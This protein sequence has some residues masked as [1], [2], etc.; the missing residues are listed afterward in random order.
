[1]AGS[2]CAEPATSTD[3]EMRLEGGSRDLGDCGATQLGFVTKS[4]IEVI[5]ELDCRTPHGY[6][7]IPEAFAPSATDGERG[8]TERLRGHGCCDPRQTSG[9]GLPR[10][11]LRQRSR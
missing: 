3:S 6:A 11:Y 1:M 5:G 4:S 10:C 8:G 7:S 2:R 9:L